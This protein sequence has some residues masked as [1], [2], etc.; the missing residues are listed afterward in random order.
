MAEDE[1]DTNF[2]PSLKKKKKK[3]KPF[4]PSVL[5]GLESTEIPVVANEDENVERRDS[6]NEDLDDDLD[7]TKKKEEE[8]EDYI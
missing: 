8:K 7:F 5:E 1:I 4:D 3:K 6:P 2:D